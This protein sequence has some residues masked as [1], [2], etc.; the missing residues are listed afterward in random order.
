M[1]SHRNL[2]PTSVTFGLSA[3]FKG[4]KGFKVAAVARS[5][6]RDLGATAL[7]T[8]YKMYSELLP[9]PTRGVQRC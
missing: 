6:R 1:W 7:T 9:S 4:F 8:K 3:G 2:K 5:V